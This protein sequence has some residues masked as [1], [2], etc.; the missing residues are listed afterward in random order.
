MK[1][2]KKIIQSGTGVAQENVLWINFKDKDIDELYLAKG[3][4]VTVKFKNVSVPYLTGLKLLYSPKTQ[5]KRF[6]SKIKY[7]KKTQWIY[8]NEFILGHYGTLEVSEELLK[9]YTKYYDTKKG[10]W[11]HNPKEQ[12]ITQRELELS[13]EL[14][15]R[16]VIRR[17]VQAEFPRKAKIGKLTKVSQR[18]YARFL[19]GYHQRFEGLMF[20]ENHIPSSKRSY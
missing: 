6:Y 11:K 7:K 4:R 12:L 9:L 20:D 10:R 1:C 16:E 18:T 19:M 14:S 15:I 2:R 13:Q 8:L 3:N 5:K 17:I